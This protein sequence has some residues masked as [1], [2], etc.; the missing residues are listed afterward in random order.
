MDDETRRRWYKFIKNLRM[1]IAAPHRFRFDQTN[2]TK[3]KMKTRDMIQL[4]KDAIGIDPSEIKTPVRENKLYGSKKS[5]YQKMESVK[6]IVRH[7]KPVE[8]DQFGSRTRNI[9]KIFVET[10]T[11]ERFLLPEGT[12]INGA[13]AYARHIKNGG[14]LTD[15][16]GKHISHPAVKI[17]RC[18]TLEIENVAPIYADGEYFGEGKVDLKVLPKSLLIM[19]NK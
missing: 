4:G 17:I 15:D 12:S 7:S 1:K 5:S 13:R 10:E 8:E 16:F 19:S 3:G 11:G 2:F 9:N 14:T 18:R 6:L